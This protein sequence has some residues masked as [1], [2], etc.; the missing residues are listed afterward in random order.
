ML[1]R[2]KNIA[3]GW[4]NTIVR[5]DNVEEIAKARLLICERCPKHSKNAKAQGYKSIRTDDHCTE[6]GC[7]LVSKTRCVSCDCPLKKWLA[8][9]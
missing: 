5:D 1:E 7:P 2:L 6:C 4:K 9:K 3:E 8:Q